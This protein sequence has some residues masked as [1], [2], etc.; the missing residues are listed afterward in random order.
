MLRP[1]ALPPPFEGFTSRFGARVTP[2]AGDML[3]GSLAIT[4]TGLS[5]ASQSWLSWTR[6][7]RLEL[8]PAI[9]ASFAH[10]LPS[11]PGCRRPRPAHAGRSR[12]SMLGAAPLNTFTTPHQVSLTET[13]NSPVFVYL[14]SPA[15]RLPRPFLNFPFQMRGA[16]TDRCL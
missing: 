6:N 11:Q 16:L 5:P 13:P 15:G 2:D 7:G 4:P 3:R 14:Q 1:V 8:N 9:F 12:S 10:R